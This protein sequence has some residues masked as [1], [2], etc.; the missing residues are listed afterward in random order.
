M[1][2]HGKRQSQGWTK[3]KGSDFIR[4]QHAAWAVVIGGIVYGTCLFD[5]GSAEGILQALQIQT[6]ECTQ[7]QEKAVIPRGFQ[8]E[9]ARSRESAP[10]EERRIFAVRDPFTWPGASG[11]ENV[12]G[13]TAFKIDRK[14]DSV[15]DGSSRVNSGNGRRDRDDIVFE[16]TAYAPT[17][18]KTAVGTVP[19]AG[20]TVA[21]DFGVL[22]PG[23]VI[24]IEGIGERVVEDTG[25]AMHGNILDLY[26]DSEAACWQFGRQRLRVTI[27]KEAD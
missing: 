8:L 3:R 4:Q 26:M 1:A 15:E 19:R 23:T 24:N 7:D 6:S 12:L 27:V 2:L 20:R 13:P 10:S 14:A 16:V 18:N 22:K 17:G 5:A 9:G 21:A 11:H 25:G